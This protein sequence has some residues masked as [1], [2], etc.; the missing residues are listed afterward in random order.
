MSRKG[1]EEGSITLHV[2]GII[3]GPQPGAIE[4]AIGAK[5]TD[6]V[7]VMIET[8]DPLF[9]TRTAMGIEDKTYMKSWIG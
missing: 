4:A 2:R 3:H 8:Y 7:A 9:L 5:S 1:I 6:E